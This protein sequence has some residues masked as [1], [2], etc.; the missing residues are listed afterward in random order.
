MEI[1][2]PHDEHFGVLDFIGFAEPEPYS[3]PLFRLAEL[4]PT[5]GNFFGRRRLSG[6]GLVGLIDQLDERVGFGRPWSSQ[7]TL[8]FLTVGWVRPQYSQLIDIGRSLSK[9]ANCRELRYRRLGANLQLGA[10]KSLP[11]PRGGVTDHLLRASVVSR[12]SVTTGPVLLL[13]E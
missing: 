8:T 10:P 12:W 3:D 2:L 7:Q 4:G 9:E 5:D 6:T 1:A 13:I 11:P